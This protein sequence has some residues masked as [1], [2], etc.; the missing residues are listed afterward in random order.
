LR[1]I[2]ELNNRA[3]HIRQRNIEAKRSEN[4]RQA[5]NKRDGLISDAYWEGRI[6]ENNSSGYWSGDPDWDNGVS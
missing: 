5:R 6:E 2:D 4:A 1:V 3:A